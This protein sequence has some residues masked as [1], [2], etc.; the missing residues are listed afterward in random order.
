MTPIERFRAAGRKVIALRRG[1]ALL[2]EGRRYG[3]EPGID[4]LRPEADI[5]W[6]DVV[7][8]CKIEVIDYS[9]VSCHYKHMNNAEFVDMMDDDNL[10]KPKPWAKCRWINIGGVSWDV[11]KAL[12]GRY[13]KSNAIASSQASLTRDTALHPLAIEDVLHHEHKGG[14]SKAD[15]YSK[16]L[17]L[18]VICHELRDPHDTSPRHYAPGPR[19]SSP[20]PIDDPDVKQALLEESTDGETLHASYSKSKNSTMRRRPLLPHTNRDLPDKQGTARSK[21]ASLLEKEKEVSL[22]AAAMYLIY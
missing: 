12:A 7:E 4:P 3:A 8:D 1:A 22:R 11:I 6:A 21:L 2:G 17:F 16:H 9:A 15:Y 5:E 20:E 13:G 19:T 14:R 10:W 18:R